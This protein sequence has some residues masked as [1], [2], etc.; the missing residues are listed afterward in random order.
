[1][2]NPPLERV[3]WVVFET[4][5]HFSHFPMRK[6]RQEFCCCTHIKWFFFW[7]C[8]PVIRHAPLQHSLFLFSVFLLTFVCLFSVSSSPR[9]CLCHA[10]WIFMVIAILG[11]SFGLW[12]QERC[13]V[14]NYIK[15]TLFT[16]S[17]ENL[18]NQK[19]FFYNRSQQKT[20]S[21]MQRS[22]KTR[23]PTADAHRPCEQSHTP[24]TTSHAF[25]LFWH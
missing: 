11:I 23:P 2:N 3:R 4:S 17:R 21:R 5:F 18:H 16:S 6:T 22:D 8:F 9:Q 1:M 10:Q 20:E 15:S 25:D 19:A 24:L 7:V 12:H 13:V 14:K